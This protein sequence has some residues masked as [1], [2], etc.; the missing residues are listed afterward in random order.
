[1]LNPPYKP[2]FHD[3]LRAECLEVSFLDNLPM[4]WG[5]SI[6]FLELVVVVGDCVISVIIKGISYR[7]VWCWGLKERLIRCRSDACTLWSSGK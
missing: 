4:G 7:N 3:L 5:M 2:P 6:K 1:M